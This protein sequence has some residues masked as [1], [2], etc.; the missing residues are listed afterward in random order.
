MYKLQWKVQRLTLE[1]HL[2]MYP[3]LLLFLSKVPESSSGS[4]FWNFVVE[5]HLWIWPP[6]LPTSGSDL[7]P[8]PVVVP[9]FK[10]PWSS[11]GSHFEICS[12][13]S[14]VNWPKN[15]DQMGFCIKFLL[16]PFQNSSNSYFKNWNLF[17][18]YLTWSLWVPYLGF[19]HL[20]HVEVKET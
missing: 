6:R 18:E 4:H 20:W 12:E 2:W 8:F 14:F 1:V 17:Y 15:W 13:N 11:S 10:V 19:M 16:A 3:K 7:F 9:L 5:T